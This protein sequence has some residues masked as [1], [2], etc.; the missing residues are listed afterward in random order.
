[1][2]RDKVG[3]ERKGEGIKRYRLLNIKQMTYQDILCRE[4]SQYFVITVN[5]V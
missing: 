2:G 1:M 5:G 3:G 4:Y